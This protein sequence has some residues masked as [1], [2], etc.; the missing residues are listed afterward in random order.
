MAMTTGLVGLILLASGAM[1]DIT[2]AVRA[3]LAPTGKL[4]AAINY[5]NFIL[6]TKDKTTGESKGAAVDLT[7]EIA[8]RLGVPVEIVA[9]DS[10]AVMGDAA[11][12]G[13]W[14]IAFLG[15]DPAREKIMSFTAAYLEIEATYLVPGASP[16]RSAADVDREGVRVAAP[17]RANYELYL[18]RNL[19]RAQLVSA[20][21]ADAAFEL[22]ATGKVEA[23]AGLTQAL[24]GLAPKLPGSRLVEGRFMGVQQSIAVPKGKD[25]GLLYLRAVVEEAKQSGLVARA[26]ERTGAKGVS[27]A[28]P[29]K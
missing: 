4:R 10:V 20:P 16:L 8:K 13:V 9:Y 19:K 18:S 24:L 27:V 12:S 11:P 3:D 6:A 21:G 5:G 26:I 15:S 14:D 2:P 28:P 25:A 1:A 29:A 17:A 7:H 23:L 22:L